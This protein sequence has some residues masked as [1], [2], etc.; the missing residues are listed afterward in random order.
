MNTFYKRVLTD[1]E[2]TKLT[3]QVATGFTAYNFFK[4]FKKLIERIQSNA[5]LVSQYL[6]T[7]QIELSEWS[8]GGN[9]SC[10]KCN[11]YLNSVTNFSYFH[12]FCFELTIRLILDQYENLQKADNISARLKQIFNSSA[13]SHK[14]KGSIFLTYLTLKAKMN[15]IYSSIDDGS[16]YEDPEF[17]FVN[18]L[19]YKMFL[20][21]CEKYFNDWEFLKI[22]KEN[23]EINF[24]NVL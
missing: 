8:F 15:F 24:I 1:K 4:L 21:T 20:E 19:N 14:Q 6:N 16:C 9:H 12:P 2:K 17:M 22:Y 18:T 11:I 23:K 3:N 5:C 7:N 13:S 10:F